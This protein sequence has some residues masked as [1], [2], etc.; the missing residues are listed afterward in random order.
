MLKYATSSPS[1][2]PC[3]CCH[4]V[5][6][7]WAVSVIRAR[8]KL[9]KSAPL[10]RRERDDLGDGDRAVAGSGDRDGVDALVL[11]ETSWNEERAV[12]GRIVARDALPGAAGT[13]DREG[14]A[15]RRV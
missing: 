3:V 6:V 12:R 13:A 4:Q 1:S 8:A 14:D 7:C 2:P 15:R 11:C 5:A 9:A 10:A